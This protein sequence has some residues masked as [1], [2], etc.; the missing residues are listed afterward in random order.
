MSRCFPFNGVSDRFENVRESPEQLN[1]EE[2]FLRILKAS[3]DKQKP[4]LQPNEN[5]KIRRDSAD[6]GRAPFGGIF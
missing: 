5:R 2:N 3:D 6:D 4:C 1:T